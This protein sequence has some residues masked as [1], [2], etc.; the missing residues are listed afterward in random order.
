[1][2]RGDGGVAE[3]IEQFQRLLVGL[4]LD[5][6]SAR[7]AREKSRMRKL[8]DQA[9]AVSSTPL[10]HPLP[11]RMAAAMIAMKCPVIGPRLER[12]CAFTGAT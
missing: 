6:R 12:G 9:S 4:R 3:L 8:L 5:R 7:R 2:A 11:F 10:A 1:M